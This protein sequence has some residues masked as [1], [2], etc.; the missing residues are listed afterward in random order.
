MSKIIHRDISPFLQALRNF[1]LGVST[2][3]SLGLLHHQRL[4]SRQLNC[5]F[6]SSATTRTPFATK[7][8]SPHAPSHHQKFPMEFPTSFRPITIF[9]ETQDAKSD[10]QRL[11]FRRKWSLTDRR[12][13]FVGE[14]ITIEP[15]HFCLILE[16]NCR[17][18]ELNT[19]F[20]NIESFL[21]RV[22]EKLMENTQ[23]LAF[24]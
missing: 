1:L 23:T 10:P 6:S 2:D 12:G 13:G 3:Y 4:A 17:L 22:E 8:P 19:N 5:E 11:S 16:P 18:Q 24:Y 14:M 7:T 21:R 20:Q 15:H 9:L